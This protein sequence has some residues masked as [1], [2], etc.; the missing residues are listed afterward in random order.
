MQEVNFDI[1]A[2]GYRY[3][4]SPDQENNTFHFL[5]E[6]ENGQVY[7]N[8]MPFIVDGKVNPLVDQFVDIVEQRKIEDAKLAENKEQ[9]ASQ[10]ENVVD[11]TYRVIDEP[12]PVQNPLPA[13][14][15]E[16]PEEEVSFEGEPAN[17]ET[18]SEEPDNT[19]DNLEV[20][21]TPS[22]IDDLTDSLKTL[23]QK[24]RSEFMMSP[25][26][27][28]GMSGLEVARKEYNTKY[29]EYITAKENNTATP[30]MDE[31]FDK[32]SMDFMQRSRDFNEWAY[33]DGLSNFVD[34]NEHKSASLRVLEEEIANKFNEI[35]INGKVNLNTKEGNVKAFSLEDLGTLTE[36][37]F[38]LVSLLQTKAVLE[39]SKKVE[40][41]RAEK[42]NNE[43]KLTEE[44]QTAFDTI[45]S[46]LGKN[47]T[48]LI[49]GV[50]G[51]GK[52]EVD[53]ANKKRLHERVLN[54]YNGLKGTKERVIKRLASVFGE[55]EVSDEFDRIQSEK[56]KEVTKEASKE[57]PEQANFKMADGSLAKVNVSKVEYVPMADQ[58]ADISRRINSLIKS[59]LTDDEL[60]AELMKIANTEHLSLG[61]VSKLS[62][63][64]KDTTE[65]TVLAERVS[66]KLNGRKIMP[67]SKS[68]NTKMEIE[69]AYS[70][71]LDKTKEKA[72]VEANGLVIPEL[73]SEWQEMVNNNPSDA[74]LY[75]EALNVMRLANNGESP[76]KIR[77]YIDKLHNASLYGNTIIKAV[78]KFSPYGKEVAKGCRKY[79]V[80]KPE[81]FIGFVLYKKSFTKLT[82][83]GRDYN[84]VERLKQ[85]KEEIAR[86]TNEV[87]EEVNTSEYTE[88]RHM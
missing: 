7:E 69:D 4:F 52:T 34:N 46:S 72:M 18:K 33:K 64:A 82:V 57:E 30:E 50:T 78:E 37:R 24:E 41:A 66:K 48:F 14:L 26:Y 77:K 47:E 8:E 5:V 54:M 32:M 55:K 63:I 58:L 68:G 42:D 43:F 73:V 10:E 53:E 23:T 80:D 35:A 51:S 70:S 29:N 9:V 22:Q 27:L 6:Y 3:K 11:G 17:E 39:A 31:E 25:E 67:L 60:N 49:H 28:V 83:D 85:I 84:E 81:R 16:E 45:K 2:K 38:F 20:T 13:D 87:N 79:L 15:V 40:R 71:D 56:E 19:N 76:R 88:G 1:I 21:I 75:N 44:Q 74:Y 59:D 36:R 86:L 12:T 65:K 62:Q 61:T